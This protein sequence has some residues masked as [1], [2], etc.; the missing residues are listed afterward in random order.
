M[1]L[2]MIIEVSDSAI[3]PSVFHKF[4]LNWFSL[5]PWEEKDVATGILFRTV[6]PRSQSQPRNM[7]SLDKRKGLSG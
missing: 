3:F 1:G 5:A 2:G 7:E 4:H 6:P